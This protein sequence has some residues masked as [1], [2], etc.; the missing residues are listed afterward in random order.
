MEI[1]PGEDKG[2]RG[3]GKND[4]INYLEIKLRKRAGAALDVRIFARET[5]IEISDGT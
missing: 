4:I 3:G 5:T 1:V 2:R